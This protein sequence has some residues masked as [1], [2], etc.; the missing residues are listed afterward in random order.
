MSEPASSPHWSY[1][2]KAIYI[3]FLEENGINAA[4]ELGVFKDI[5]WI[6]YAAIFS[7]EVSLLDYSFQE[8]L[9]V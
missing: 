1:L 6:K 3:K 9:T 4:L 2:E 8:D 5:Y 7:T